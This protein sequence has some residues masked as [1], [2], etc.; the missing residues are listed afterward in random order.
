MVC[1]SLS[2]YVRDTYQ[3][4]PTLSVESGRQQRLFVPISSTRR[5]CAGFATSCRSVGLHQSELYLKVSFA[6]KLVLAP[7][8][9]P[10]LVL[11]PFFS[12][13]PALRGSIWC[14]GTLFEIHSTCD[15]E[16]QPRRKCGRGGEGCRVLCLLQHPTRRHTHKARPSPL[17]RRGGR[18]ILC[19]WSS[20]RVQPRRRLP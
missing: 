1:F 7:R 14:G 6:L 9:P 10:L 5:W 15:I 20:P 18:P 4:Y 13:S 12:S 3:L 19:A 8:A 11:H 2:S 16:R 17:Q